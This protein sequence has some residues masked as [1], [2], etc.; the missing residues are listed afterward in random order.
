MHKEAAHLTKDT[1][2]GLLLLQGIRSWIVHALSN[3]PVNV[4]I[5]FWG[6]E[7][8]DNI[9]HNNSGK[10]LLCIKLCAPSV[11]QKLLVSQDPLVLVEAYLNDEFTFNGKTDDLILF[12]EHLSKTLAGNNITLI[13]SWLERVLIDPLRNSGLSLNQCLVAHSPAR[14]RAVIQIHY[15]TGNEF[16]R[17]WLDQQMI[18]SCAYFS[19]KEM[20]LDQAQEAKLDLICRKLQLTAKDKLLDVGCGWGAMLRWAAK[21]YGV[22]HAHGITLSQE[23]LEWNRN[24]IIKEGLQNQI[25]VELADY[26]ELPEGLRFNKIV[27]VGMIEHVG[28]AKYP[29]YFHA[30][31]SALSPGG[32]LLNHGITTSSKWSNSRLAER[33]MQHYIFPDGELSDLPTVLNAAKEAGWEIIDVESLRPHYAKTLR[34]WSNNLEQNKEKAS[35]LAGVRKVKLWSIYLTGSALA[36]QNNDLG[37]FQTLLRRSEDKVWDLPLSRKNWLF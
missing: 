4:S 32:L 34:C 35:K 13:R 11:L 22:Q 6:Q 16:Y 29:A 24:W 37:I 33:F 5:D 25:S 18:Y 19:Q 28:I 15:D 27:S 26:R 2:L 3:A 1:G 14:D 30:L 21:K 7:Q 8:I 17:L 31:L 9:D 20:T 36:F 12:V 10:E 23:Q